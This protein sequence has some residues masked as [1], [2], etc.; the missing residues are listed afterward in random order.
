MQQSKISLV[1]PMKKHTGEINSRIY[2]ANGFWRYRAKKYTAKGCT[3]HALKSVVNVLPRKMGCRHCKRTNTSLVQVGT[4]VLRLVRHG[5]VNGQMT[6][7][8]AYIETSVPPSPS[9]LETGTPRPLNRDRYK[10]EWKDGMMHGKGTFMWSKG[11]M[12]EGHWRAGKMHGHG[13]KKM[14]NGDVYEGV[15]VSFV[16]F[17]CVCFFL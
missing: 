5:M 17:V 13:V 16:S 12:Y 9:Q 14:G 2:K 4:A 6:A 8:E 10:G 7:L 3:R 11:D 15:F 1:L